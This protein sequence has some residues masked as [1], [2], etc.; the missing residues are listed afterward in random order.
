MPAMLELPAAVP[1]SARPD[2]AR[3]LALSTD[4][5]ERYP[6]IFPSARRFSNDA[7]PFRLI[8]EADFHRIAPS[9]P[10]CR[11]KAGPVAQAGNTVRV[12]TRSP[13]DRQTG[14]ARQD[15]GGIPDAPA[16]P[17]QSPDSTGSAE[18]AAPLAAIAIAADD[19]EAVPLAGMMGPLP[20]AGPH[21]AAAN[22]HDQV[23]DS[24]SRLLGHLH[25][26]NMRPL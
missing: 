20:F 12:G 8:A 5:N 21:R 19:P 23:A 15:A 11:A 9:G 2:T 14:E 16:A 18:S 13:D 10:S 24:E 26:V 25:E 4:T 7:P 3:R 22:L 1:L 17:A 6:Q